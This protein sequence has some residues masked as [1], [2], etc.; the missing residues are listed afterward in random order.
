MFSEKMD[1]AHGVRVGPVRELSTARSDRSVGSRLSTASAE[2]LA[3]CDVARRAAGVRGRRDGK[4]RALAVEP[5]RCIAAIEAHARDLGASV[6]R[7]A[8]VHVRVAYDEGEREQARSWSFWC[9]W[10][11]PC[12]SVHR[13]R[14]VS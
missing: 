14:D 4:R 10:I 13:W 3:S 1:D 5:V 6:L 2:T 9:T 12:H 8:V 7:L 11:D